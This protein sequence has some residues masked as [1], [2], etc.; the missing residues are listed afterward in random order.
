MF[1][2]VTV[3][4]LPRGAW[5]YA[6]YVDGIYA[7]FGSLPPA[8]NKLDIAVFSSGNARCLDVEPGDATNYDIYGWF[9]R[10]R[11]RGVSQPVIYTS[12][13]NI[14]AVVN[15]MS[16]NGFSRDEYLIWSAHYTGYAHICGNCGYPRADATQYA[17]NNYYDT[18]LCPDNFFSGAPAPG[19]VNEDV[20]MTAV[21]FYANSWYWYAIGPDGK[22]NVWR[23][24]NYLGQVPGVVLKGSL[25]ADLD[26]YGNVCMLGKGLDNAMWEMWE[27]AGKGTWT[28]VKIPGTVLG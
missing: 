21:L 11:Q 8:P 22:L 25:S 10:Q 4:N 6:G 19:Y 23:D 20:N 3:G 18:S 7:N 14:Q 24:R 9:V 2:S 13:S 5:A 17:S 28:V 26:T 27:T 12:A 15:T 16:A 1:D